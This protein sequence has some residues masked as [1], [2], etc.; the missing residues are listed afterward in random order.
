MNAKMESDK[1]LDKSL[2]VLV[3]IDHDTNWIS[4]Y[5]A[6]KKGYDPYAVK[7]SPTLQVHCLQR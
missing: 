2:P 3:G 4:A 1:T 7:K 5:T 6:S